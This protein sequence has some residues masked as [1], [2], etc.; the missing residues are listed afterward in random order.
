MFLLQAIKY[1][2]QIF[3]LDEAETYIPGICMFLE[4]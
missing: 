2:T 3:S 4:E 1:Y